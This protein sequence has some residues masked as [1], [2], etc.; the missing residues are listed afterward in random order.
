[1]FIEF[2]GEMPRGTSLVNSRV[3]NGNIFHNGNAV[4][5]RY[6]EKGEYLPVFNK[7][8]C[9]E[10]VCGSG[11]IGPLFLNFT[12]VVCES[13]YCLKIEKGI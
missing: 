5:C 3:L 12:L 1:V 4:L 13:Q 7:V 9:H 2:Y 8:V 6:Y 10:D 11:C